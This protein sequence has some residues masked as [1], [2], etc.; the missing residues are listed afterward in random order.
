[1]V[2]IPE[3]ACR[4]ATQK[5]VAC[6]EQRDTNAEAELAPHARLA[7]R[8]Q[9][10]TQLSTATGTTAMFAMNFVVVNATFVMYFGEQS[11]LDKSGEDSPPI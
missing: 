2:Y 3:P 6:T 4:C 10:Q 8:Q 5:V 9:D 11:Q 7:D 1:M